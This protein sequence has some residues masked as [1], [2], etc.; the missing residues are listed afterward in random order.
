[1]DYYSQ[2]HGPSAMGTVTEPR[3]TVDQMCKLLRSA[4]PLVWALAIVL[5]LLG[6]TLIVRYLW[7]KQKEVT[8]TAR[9]SMTF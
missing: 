1:M 9:G 2:G 7:K 3:M 6:V 8:E 4:K 5:G